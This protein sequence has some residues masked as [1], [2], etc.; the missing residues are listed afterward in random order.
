[1]MNDH[2]ITLNLEIKMSKK[3]ILN[4]QTVIVFS[5]KMYFVSFTTLQRCVLKYLKKDFWT[6][7]RANTHTNK[8]GK[9]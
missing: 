1:M 3:H 8:K 4:R 7:L 6:V 2:N 5:R 9:D